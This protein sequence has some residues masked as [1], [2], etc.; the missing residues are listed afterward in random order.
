MRSLGQ[1][2]KHHTLSL[3][4]FIFVFCCIFPAVFVRPALAQEA[5]IVGT[6]TDPSGAAV[7]NATIT[8]TN[9]DTG[10]ARVITTN[11]EGHYV[12]PELRIG[13]YLVNAAATGF[14]TAERKDITLQV[15]DRVRIDFQMQMGMAQDRITVEATAVAVQADSSE[16]SQVVTGQQLLSDGTNGRSFYQYVNLTPGVVSLQADQQVA[17]TTGGDSNFSVNGNRSGHNIWLLDGGEALD[18]GGSGTFA[19]MPSV[20]A[21]AEFRV[22]SSNYDAEYGLSSAG[23]MTTVLKSGTKT[24]HGSAW[25]FNRNDALDARN[26]FSRV[27][28]RDSSGNVVNPIPAFK[29]NIFGF[30]IGGPI[31]FMKKEHKSFFFYNM[32]WRKLRSGGIYN[33]TV[34]LASEY[35]NAAGDAVIPVAVNVPGV[36][37]VAPSVLFANCPGGVAPAGIVQGSPFPNSTIPSCMISANSKALLNAGIFPKPTSG[38]Q[39][40]GTSNSPTN[41]REEIVRIDHTFNDKFA[42]FGHYVDEATV[43][44]FGTSMWTNDNVPTVGNTYAN[45]SRSAVVHLTHTIKPTLLNEVTFNYNGN[46][47]NIMP[48]GVYAQPS[49]STFNRIFTGTNTLN[50][51]PGVSL[52]GT[53]GTNYTTGGW[54]WVN[55][56]DSYQIKGD[57]SWSRGS[58]QLKMGA[59]F[60]LYKKMQELN[61]TVQGTYTFNSSFTGNDFADFLLGT[62]QAYA[63]DALH[64][65]RQWNNYSLATYIQDNWR[66]NNR[67]TLNLGLRWDGA[68]HTYEANHA[69]SNFYPDRYNPALMPIFNSSS[70]LN[71]SSPGLGVSPNPLLAGYQ[72][73]LNGIAMDGIGVPKGL[74]NVPWS[75]FGPRLGFAYDVTGHGSTVIRGGIGEMFE[76]VQGNDIYD[77]GTNVPFSANVGLNNVLLG[78]PTMALVD[79]SILP[80]NSVMVTNITGLSQHMYKMP[81]S[82]QFSM[83][84]QQSLGSKTVLSVAYVGTQNRHQSDRRNINLVNPSLLPALVAG[85]GT[86]N[87][88]VPYQGFRSINMSFDEGNSHYNGMQVSLQGHPM[89]DLNLQGGYTLSRAIDSATGSGDGWDLQ[90]VTNPY[91]GWKGDIGTSSLDRTQVAYINF[92]YDLPFFRSSSSRATKAI[93]GGWKLAGIGSMWTGAPVNVNL[94]GTTVCSVVPNCTVRP[95]L[96]GSISYPKSVTY[97]ANTVPVVQWFSTGSFSA[98][99]AGTFGN[100]PRNYLLGPGRDNWNLSLS[101]DFNFTE[102][103]HLQ[104]RFDAFNA[105]NH[106]Q[107]NAYGTSGFASSSLTTNLAGVITPGKV[108]QITR[109]FDPRKLQ[110]SLKLAF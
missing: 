63:E 91:V 10:Q 104:F 24:L 19:V 22:L 69:T 40:T 72:F 16:I 29:Q 60:Q 1:A 57:V 8:V 58:H 84:V 101:K 59:S 80:T 12:V 66:V 48:V 14:R 78:K 6:V 90:N 92:I 52:S 51:I 55:K 79:G 30:N 41:V 75:N 77:A 36:A 74:V 81:T 87:Q 4:M 68:P 99:A 15:G 45:P 93:I 73:Y 76:R 110:L 103:S 50:R 43:Q 62:A 26:Y 109:A 64:D 42:I 105:F 95:N 33:Q 23:T 46:R 70:T 100:L 5:T 7:P 28:T 82:W 13:H 31:D 9:I 89:R 38:A 39:F 86:W 83:G 98:P 35:P 107:L 97:A 56:Y 61:T 2:A 53:T 65:P 88:L 49:G 17:A 3:F 102:R 54:P 37:K 106:T 47:I 96:T 108:G 94:G 18:R 67:L 11:S 34:P 20:D 44:G 25:E 21:V 27:P 32:E 85:T 71:I